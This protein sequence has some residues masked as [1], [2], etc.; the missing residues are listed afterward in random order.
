MLTAAIHTSHGFASAFHSLGLNHEKYFKTVKRLAL[1][2]A[3][4]VGGGFT[5]LSIW[6]HLKGV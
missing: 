1:F 4:T 3:I 5:F 6:C 2:Y